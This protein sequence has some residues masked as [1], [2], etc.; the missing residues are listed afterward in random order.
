MVEETGFYQECQWYNYQVLHPPDLY[1]T[2]WTPYTVFSASK[3]FSSYHEP[4]KGAQFF[5]S[6]VQ[7]HVFTAQNMKDQTLL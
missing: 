3:I 7:D 6:E 2:D 4:Q 5:Y 1:F